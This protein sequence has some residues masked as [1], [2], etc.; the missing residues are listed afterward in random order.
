MCAKEK[1][2][3]RNQETVTN[4]TTFNIIKKMLWIQQLWRT[5]QIMRNMH[6][7][8]KCNVIHGNEERANIF[9]VQYRI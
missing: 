5:I 3:H 1:K 7:S 4:K 2:L 6:K 8:N 9:T